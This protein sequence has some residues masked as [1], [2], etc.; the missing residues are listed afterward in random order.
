MRPS[1]IENTTFISLRSIFRTSSS[2]RAA[3]LSIYETPLIIRF[4]SVMSKL[5]SL[6]ILLLE[7]NNVSNTR[8]ML[9]FNLNAL[10]VRTP[11]TNLNIMAQVVKPMKRPIA[12]SG[13]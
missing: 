13:M 10:G 6:S 4:F 2:L 11:G 5:L 3:P 12:V 7:K 1:K 8:N 9:L